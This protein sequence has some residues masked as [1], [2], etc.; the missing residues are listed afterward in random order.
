MSAQ[1]YAERIKRNLSTF[2][3]IENRPHFPSEIQIPL[4]N[5][6]SLWWSD[7]IHLQGNRCLKL[8]D[9]AIFSE[10]GMM[11]ERSFSYDFREQESHKMIWRICNHKTWQPVTNGCHV[12]DNPDDEDA[13]NECFPDSTKTDF[14]YVMH[15]LKNFYEGKPQDWEQAQ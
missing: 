12:H 11:A 13:R 10:D 2:Q 7:T 9:A 5:P 6:F 8:V 15:C 14:M 4:D 3:Y 1:E